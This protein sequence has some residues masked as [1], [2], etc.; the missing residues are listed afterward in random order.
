M[1]SADALPRT[2][3]VT[4]V[5]KQIGELLD[6]DARLQNLRVMGEVADLRHTAPGHSY[7]TLRERGAAIRCVLFRNGSGRK[8][9]EDGAQVICNGRANL[10]VNQG[11]L[12]VIA[13]N[14]ESAGMGELLAEIA[15]LRAKLSAEGLF[16]DSRKRPLPRMPTRI[17]VITS[18]SGSAWQDICEVLRRRYPIAEVLLLPVAVQGTAAPRE[19][20]DALT[21]LDR[22]AATRRVDVAILARGGGANADLMAFNDEAVARAI[23]SC[24]VPLVSG[25]GHEDDESIS[26]FVADRRAETPSAAAELVTEDRAELR[27]GIRAGARMMMRSTHDRLRTESERLQ[28]TSDRVEINIDSALKRARERHSGNVGRLAVSRPDPAAKLREVGQARARLGN[29]MART[30]DVVKARLQGVTAQLNALSYVN[31]LNRGYTI[32]RDP[33][34]QVVTRAAHANVGMRYKLTMSD[35]SVSA[36]AVEVQL[37]Q[38]ATRDR[39]E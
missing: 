37:D 29:S 2:R 3:T 8:H 14:V 33:D 34:G 35:G 20:V 17:A 36:D 9:L 25:V 31:T 12:Q 38:E 15:A 39:H 5:A 18:E 32:V 28:Q 26:D 19:I 7:F 27:T 23:F 21:T 4:E 6:G 30:T 11:T 16:E 24:R 13:N 1:A 10:Y 22:Y